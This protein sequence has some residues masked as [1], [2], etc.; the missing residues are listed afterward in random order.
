METVKGTLRA[1]SYELFDHPSTKQLKPLGFW[2]RLAGLYDSPQ[3]K[4]YWNIVSYF[5]FLFL[6]A[7]VLMVDFQCTPSWT[8][9]LLYIWV[10]SLVCEEVR[11]L[12]HD[13]DGFGFWKKVK[14]HMNDL[15]NILDVLSIV[16]FIVGLVCRLTVELFYTGKVLLCIDF[17]IFCLR[18]IAIFTISKTLGPKII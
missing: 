10:A 17:I 4:F 11:Q 1:N 3:V 15:W 18:L 2:A 16:F 14:M 8:E 5:A 6:F 7:V 12:F 13:A 9:V